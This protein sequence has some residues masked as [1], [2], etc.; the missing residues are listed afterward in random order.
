MTCPFLGL[1]NS[2]PNTGM[3]PSPCP[4]PCSTPARAQKRRQKRPNLAKSGQK[5][6]RTMTGSDLPTAY[7]LQPAVR[8]APRISTFCFPNFCFSLRPFPARAP[9]AGAKKCRKVQKGAKKCR[10]GSAPSVRHVLRS[11]S[12][13]A[14]LWRASLDASP[15]AVQWVVDPS[16]PTQQRGHDRNAGHSLRQWLWCPVKPT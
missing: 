5:W 7:S 16:H 3:L 14:A 2:V 10:V 13:V 15:A 1:A 4:K 8:P 12:R 11:T 6:P 9:K